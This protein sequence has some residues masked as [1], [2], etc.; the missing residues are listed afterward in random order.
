MITLLNKIELGL[1]T[2]WE[3]QRAIR[4]QF[5]LGEIRRIQD[6]KLQS[7]IRYCSDNIK[8]YKEVFQKD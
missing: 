5:D 6:T 3:A 8:Y 7:L 4:R 1:H 2:Y